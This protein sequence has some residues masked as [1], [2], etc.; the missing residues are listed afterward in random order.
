MKISV[1]LPSATAVASATNHGQP[2]VLSKPDHPVS[3]AISSLAREVVGELVGATPGEP[4]KRG[5][6][7]RSKKR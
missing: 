5:L 6:F 7:G 2:I 1:S 4:V 3:K